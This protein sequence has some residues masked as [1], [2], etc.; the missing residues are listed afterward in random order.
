V[1]DPERAQSSAPPP[2]RAAASPGSRPAAA[3]STGA[4]PSWLAVALPT[5]LALAFRLHLRRIYWGS[6]EEDYGNLGLTL[7]TLQSG[8][9]FVETEHMPLFTHLAAAAAAVT[10]D[11]ESG[12]EA[13]AIAFGSAT[14]ALLAALGARWFSPAVG[15]LSGLLAA[16]QP[17]MALFSSTP[18]RLAPYTALTLA[19]VGLA[20]ERR[21]I[22]AGLALS[23]AFLTRFDAAFTLLPAFLLWA[24]LAG[25]SRSGAGGPAGA[26]AAAAPAPRLA[27][28]LAPALG[29]AIPLA[30]VLAWS[31]FYS[32]EH[33]TW[34][35]W[36]DV[37]ARNT[38]PGPGLLDPE[39]IAQGFSTLFAVS[40]R[41]LPPHI[42]HAVLPLAALGAASLL[43]RPGHAPGPGRAVR[44][45]WFL[46]CAA[47]TLGF[48]CAVV[49]LSAYRWDHNMYW[50][51]LTPSVPFLLLLAAQGAI[52]VISALSQRPRVP[53]ALALGLAVATALDF[54]AETRRQLDRSERWYGTQVR[55][56]ESADRAAAPEAAFLADL[57]P[58]AWIGR[59]SGA[60][61]L[62]SWSDASLPRGDPAA[63]GR[64]LLARR[65]AVVFWFREDW[66]GAEEAAPFL[67]PGEPVDAGPVRLVPRARED[68]YGWI[69]YSVEP[70]P[71]PEPSPE[72]A[73]Q[74]APPRV[75]SPP[76]D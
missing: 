12:G 25:W 11:T 6:E 28:P 19:F 14:V 34:A 5:L 24:L 45:A 73:T 54:R 22:A 60:R 46:A 49:V 75:P 36:G 61:E 47:L 30:V 37:A 1:I 27:S 59:R 58:A 71:A 8:F 42:G 10:G 43:R 68:G 69:G 48:F 66:V 17:E 32:R 67:S 35:F 64:W 13:V 23:L 57:I 44:R 18:L 74:P 56:A 40:T 72:A 41:V 21:W 33:G 70:A 38:A 51:W 9:R 65:V 15:L 16:F 55:F 63:F 7:G 52:T 62:I 29:F 4:I 26:A 31:A 3:S 20:A 39:R 2:A 50:K 53:I 76:G